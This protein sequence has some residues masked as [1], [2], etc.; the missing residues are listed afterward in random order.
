MKKTDGS[1]SERDETRLSEQ[2]KLKKV[3]A[4][5]DASVER[6]LKQMHDQISE[7]TDD[8]CLQLEKVLNTTQVTD[9]LHAS[10]VCI[11]IF[12]LLGMEKTTRCFIKRTRTV[13]YN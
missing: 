2:D 7:E 3:A 6:R 1:R 9:L 4:D 5:M 12:G 8:K 10:F 13:D 11:A